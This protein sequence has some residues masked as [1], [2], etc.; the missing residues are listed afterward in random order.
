MEE[1]NKGKVEKVFI[2]ILKN[3]LRIEGKVKSGKDRGFNIFRIY[4]PRNKSL[5]FNFLEF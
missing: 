1:E 2:L 4:L 5:R 3:D